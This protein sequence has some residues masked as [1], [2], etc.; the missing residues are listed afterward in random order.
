MHEWTDD[1][2]EVVTDWMRVHDIAM[3]EDALEELRFDIS[4]TLNWKTLVK[5]SAMMGGR[6]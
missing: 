4:Y 2:M 3:D 6:V 1:L 5:M